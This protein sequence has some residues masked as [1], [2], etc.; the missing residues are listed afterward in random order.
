MTE[1]PALILKRRFENGEKFTKKKAKK[2]LLESELINKLIP[3][4]TAMSH[5]ELRIET[6]AL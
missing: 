4:A 5:S 1:D 6:T 2:M 3:P